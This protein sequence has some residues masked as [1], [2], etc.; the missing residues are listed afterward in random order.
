MS[1]DFCSEDGD[2]E[3]VVIDRCLAPWSNRQKIGSISFTGNS[4]KKAV[5]YILDSCFTK[6]G[7]NISR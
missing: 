2:G 1:I 4:L 3:F 5:K 6:F 7:N